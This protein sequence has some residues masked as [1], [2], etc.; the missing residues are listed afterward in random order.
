MRDTTDESIRTE[1]DY[2]NKFPALNKLKTERRSQDF[3]TSPPI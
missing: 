3:N 1:E 2:K